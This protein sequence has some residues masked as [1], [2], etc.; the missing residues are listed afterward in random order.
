VSAPQ[1][2]TAIEPRDVADW[3]QQISERLDAYRSRHSS[4]NENFQPPARPHAEGR[5]WSS[6]IARAVASRYAAAPSYSEVL[7]QAAL[8][9]QLAEQEARMA[10]ARRMLEAAEA[11]QQPLPLITEDG[12]GEVTASPET[13]AAAANPA[14]DPAPLTGTPVLPQFPRT[15]APVVRQTASE[16]EPSL[17]E[18]LASSVVEPRAPLPSKLIEFPRELVSPRRARPKDPE[19]PAPKIPADLLPDPAQ[20]R[21]FEVQSEGSR[22]PVASKPDS[23]ATQPETGH[24]ASGCTLSEMSAQVAGPTIDRP[25]PK[26]A[27]SEE[28]AASQHAVR[29]F[30]NLEWASISLDREPS[31]V[32]R[33]KESQTAEHVPFLT[34]LASIDRRLMAFAVDFTAVTG[35]FL[36]F[37]LVFAAC[38]TQIPTGRPAIV[39]SAAVYGALWVIYQLLFFTL[40]GATAG[41]LYARI[42]LCTFED[43]NPTPRQIRARMAAWWL[44]C[45][46]LGLGFLWC[47]VDED[48]LGWHDRITRTY[49]R[50]Y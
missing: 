13:E 39:L 45:L 19:P 21:I 50:E 36:A 35:A 9:E 48:S 33:G 12:P 17:E 34:D 49:Q 3:K 28:V 1:Q 10:H 4:S 31:A 29:T 47:F 22:T 18:F 16:P 32:S 24:S 15:P 5:S 43:Q 20:L 30:R 42:A 6:P 38:T 44:A 14:T 23:T 11:G 7:Q 37:L 25:T 40:S 41:M 2:E 26:S 46:P 8:R 27:F